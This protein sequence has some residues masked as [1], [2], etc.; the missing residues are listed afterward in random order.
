LYTLHYL[1][2]A[3]FH[4]F[5]IIAFTGN[6]LPPGKAFYTFLVSR[7][8]GTQEQPRCRKQYANI[9]KGFSTKTVFLHLY[10]AL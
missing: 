5:Q 9:S 6:T 4:I 3:P 1:S 2:S 7:L 10:L 8:Q